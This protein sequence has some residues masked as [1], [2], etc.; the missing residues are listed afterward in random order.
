MSALP[1]RQLPIR[2][3]QFARAGGRAPSYATCARDAPAKHCESKVS[4]VGAH[5][6]RPALSVVAHLSSPLSVAS[7]VDQDGE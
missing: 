5:C 4:F 2:G 3:R 7:A 1:A 6:L